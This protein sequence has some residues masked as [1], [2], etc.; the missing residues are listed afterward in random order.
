M[1]HFRFAAHVFCVAAVFLMTWFILRKRVA[2][3]NFWHYVILIVVIYA[4]LTWFINIQAD[5]AEGLQTSYLAER[6][7][8]NGD[9]RVM[10]R[11]IPSYRAP[12]EHIERRIHG[13]GDGFC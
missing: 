6:E 10:Q 9:F 1:K 5:A 7:L 13:E 8:E 2:H 4:I 3:S 12:L 11:L